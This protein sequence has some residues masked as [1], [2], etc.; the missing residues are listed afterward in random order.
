MW[1]FPSKTLEPSSHFMTGE[2]Q[3]MDQAKF[4]VGIAGLGFGQQHLQ[5]FL[6]LPD[7]FKVTAL[8]DLDLERAQKLAQTASSPI[9]CASFQD[10]LRLDL[11]IISICT[12]SYLHYEHC[13]AALQSGKH[14]ILE[15]PPAGSLRE[16]D[17]LKEAAEH[18]QHLLMPIFAQRFGHGVQKMRHLIAKGVTGKPILATAETAWRRRPEYYQTWHGKWETELGGALV[19]LGIH[20]HDVVCYLL[21]SVES[22]QAQIATSVNPI[23]TEDTVS[24][25]LRMQNGALVSLAVTTGCAAETSRLHFCFSA[26]SAQSN[27]SAYAYPCEPWD[28]YGDTPE[29]QT[30]IEK[31]LADFEPLPEDLTGQFYRFYQSLTHGVP[32]PVTIEDAHRA[33]ELITAIYASARSGERIHLPILPNSPF[34]AGWRP[35]TL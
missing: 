16:V 15:K 4:R 8:C 35:Q 20:A 32:L 27:T 3:G 19:T 6:Q 23:E 11:D 7:Q 2:K 17:A 10:L 18:S 24:A 13:L 21:G 33:V 34:Y 5:A 1:N 25:A 9:V 28:F 29:A 31:A 22:V 26:L 14:V 12:P 30:Q